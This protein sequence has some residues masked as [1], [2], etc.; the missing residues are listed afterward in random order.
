M[1]FC[2]I[3]IVIAGFTG[4]EIRALSVGAIESLNEEVIPKIPANVL[5]VVDFFFTL[6]RLMNLKKNKQIQ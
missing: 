4:A 3:E 2:Y 6:F 1:I 5:K